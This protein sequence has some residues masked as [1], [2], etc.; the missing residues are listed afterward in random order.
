MNAPL[1]IERKYLIDKPSEADLCARFSARYRDITQTYLLSR[2][3]EGRRVRRSVF[4]DGRVLYQE[5]VKIA[6]SV[7]TSEER[8]RTLDAEEYERLLLLRDPERQT[9]EKRRY[10]IPYDGHILE[11]DVYPFWE[12]TAVLEIE[13]S[14]ED[15]SF[16]LP[17][18]LTV[19]REVSAE[20]AFKNRALALHVPREEDIRR[21]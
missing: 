21:D 12:R 16:T 4:D 7:L 11:I 13:L 19:L 17:A 15:E 10:V 2:S 14:T 6:V 18:F 20:K 1:E 3:G 5:T 9:I 8:E